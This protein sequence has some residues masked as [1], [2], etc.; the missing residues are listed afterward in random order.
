LAK[1]ESSLQPD[2]HKN[3]TGVADEPQDEEVS[4]QLI[5]FV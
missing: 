4:S 1:P 5:Y 2:Q 3:Q